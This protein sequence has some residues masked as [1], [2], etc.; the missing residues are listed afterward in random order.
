MV[1]MQPIPTLNERKRIPE[2]VIQQTVRSIADRFA[3][4]RIILFGSYA[5]GTVRPESDVDLLIIIKTD[6]REV[7]VALAIRRWLQPRFALDLVVITPERLQ[8][9][10]EWGDS[11]LREILQKGVRCMNPCQ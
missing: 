10:L 3:P 2:E 11:F 8:Q 5:V 7:D 1:E 6:Q 9:R 4:Q